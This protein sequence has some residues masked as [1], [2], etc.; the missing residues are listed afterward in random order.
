[1]DLKH[2]YKDAKR[3]KQITGVMFK[4]GLGYYLEN[5]KLNHHLFIHQRTNT[6]QIPEDL[7]RKLRMAMDELGGTF[8]KLGQ[9]LSLRPDLIPDEYCKEF[10]KLQDDVTPVKYEVIRE[11]V[12]NELKHSIS[13]IFSYFDKEP[14]ASA[15]IGQVHKARLLNGTRVVVKIQRP[16]IKQLMEEDIDL[17]YH[18]SGI[19]QH[20]IPSFEK[21][22]PKALV[23]EFKRYTEEE[24]DYLKEGRNIDKF[25]HNFKDYDKMKVPKVFW[26]F[27]TNKVLT[28]GY[29][30]GIPIDD[31]EG[32]KDW[33][34]NEK[35]LS[36]NLADVFL[37][38]VFEFGFFHADPHPANLFVLPGNKIALL[39]YG[40]CGT[41]KEKDRE[42][43]IDMLIYLVH[44]DI[45][46]VVEKFL[47]LGVLEDKNDQ[48]AEEL[49]SLVEEY[50]EANLE[51]IDAVKLFTQM[52]EVAKKYEFRLP[53][54][55]VLLVKAIVTI[56]GVGQSLDKGFNLGDKLHEYTDTLIS[57]KLRP[58]HIAKAIVSD[59]NEFKDNVTSIPRQINE[60]LI[61][62]RKGELG[63][64]FERKDLVQLERE[65]D[66]SSNRVSMG[67]IIAALVVAS[68]LVLQVNNG[69]WL[70][71]VGFLIAIFLTIGLIISVM[72]E[73]RVIV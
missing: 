14:I 56:E 65:I 69:K 5:L 64:H 63:V 35:E 72:N 33:G 55:F 50:A 57:K 58:S 2:A 26:D 37:K 44:R 30:D 17:L 43:L 19:A 7:P 31:K 25:Y 10:S 11:T 15:S 12:E 24:L 48:L 73:R 42:S 41:L 40:I 13:E 61:K 20:Q 9:L 22:N 70:A 66:K 71:V 32:F 51:Q 21:Y 54:D 1:M 59:I 34:C 68:A 29:I 4:T 36:N 62:L 27:T 38:Q 46:G 49:S 39:D 28:M 3:L 67:I 23:D 47:S 18:L 52:I 8:V 53:A 16:N 60:I 45:N 6:D